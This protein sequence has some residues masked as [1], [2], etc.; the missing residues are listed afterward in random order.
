MAATPTPDLGSIYWIEPFLQSL[1]G[2]HEG[3]IS[4]YKVSSVTFIENRLRIEW[5]QGNGGMVL[6][7]NDGIHYEGNYSFE[8]GKSRGSLTGEY[9]QNENGGV[10]FGRWNEQGRAFSLLVKLAKIK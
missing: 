3:G 7:T 10:L 5:D 9:Y 1:F 8:N 4:A 6:T 2:E